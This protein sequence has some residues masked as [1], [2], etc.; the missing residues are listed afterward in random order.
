VK[1]GRWVSSL[2][3]EPL[4]GWFDRVVLPRLSALDRKLVRDLGALA[5]QGVTIALVVGAGIGGFIALRSTFTSLQESRATYYERYRFGDGF[6]Q[7]ERAPESL[8]ARLEAVPGVALAYTRVVEGVRIPQ[9]GQVQSPVGQIVTLPPGGEAP[10]NGVL[11]R[12]GRLP[13]TGRADEALLLDAFAERWGYAPGDTVRVVANGALRPLLVTGLATS[14]EFIYPVPAGGAVIPDEERFAVF[15]MDRAGAAPLFQMEGAFNDVVLRFNRGASEREVLAGVDALLEPYGGRGA[16]GRA[17]QP[18][19]YILEGELA[20]LRQFATVVPVIFLGVAA[21]LLN[22]VLS[23]LLHLQRTQVASLKALGYRNREIALHFLKMSSGVVV[24]G[25]LLGVGVGAWLGQAMTNLYGSFFGFPVLLWQMGWGPP[26]AGVAVALVAGTAGTWSALRRILALSP[27]EAMSPEP[28]ARYRPSILER[29]GLGRLVGPSGRMVLREVG[30]R[31]LRTGLSALGIGLALGIV[32]VGR[33][34]ADALDFLIDE[35]FYRAW[36]EDVTVSFTGP[37]D[38]RG[39][40]ELLALPGVERAEG[41]RVTAVRMEHGHRWRDVPLQGYP[42]G[43]R[44]RQL[45]DGEGRVH[46]PPEGGVVLTTKLAEVLGLE[47]G[48]AVRVRLREGPA[49]RASLEVTGLVDEMF[50]LQGHMRLADLN[51]LLHEGPRVSQALLT[52]RSDLYPALE[53]R[54]ARM[55]AVADVGSRDALVGRFRAQSGEL[56]VVMTLILTVFASIIAAGVVYNNARVALSM[57]ERD[58]ASLRVLGFTRREI[59]AVLLGEMGVQ[60]LLAIPLG[61]WVGIRLCEGIAGAVD[62]ERY[63]LPVVLGPATYAYAIGVVLVASAASAFL[64]RR[65]LDDLD[66]IGV[67]KTRE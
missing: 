50:G 9:P 38:S 2:F 51:A 66:L 44:L 53:A 65:R 20:Q 18:S 28:P 55:P 41:V 34:S 26:V 4:K 61:V 67:L 54:L 37:V 47:V 3:L 39:V 7:L 1:P 36:R 25:S 31:P 24:A 52:V 56:L 49:G 40:R 46:P 32:M 8:A 64:V 59:S 62:P 42:E 15:W 10:L 6:A 13:A 57:R 21:F 27:A 22:V 33:F 14:P 63:R 35:Q 17:L 30:R 23:R 58:L 5:G 29:L 45:I 11:L 43:A 12:E 60:V 16:Y 19:N 48:D